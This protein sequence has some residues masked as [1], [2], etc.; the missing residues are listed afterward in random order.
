MERAL[1]GKIRKIYSVISMMVSIRKIR[2]TVRELLYGEVVTNTSETTS[3]MKEKA[4]EKCFSQMALS[5]R[6]NGQEAS[7]TEKQ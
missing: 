4:T 2:K 3:T 5:T 7:K 1:G 6:V